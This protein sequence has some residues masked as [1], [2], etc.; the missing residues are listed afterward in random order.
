VAAG[1]FDAIGICAGSGGRYSRA[2]GAR[3]DDPRAP[4]SIDPGGVV[5]WHASERLGEHAG[6]AGNG[7]LG[8]A[9]NRWHGVAGGWWRFLTRA[10]SRAFSANLN[11]G[12]KKFTNILTL[13]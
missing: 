13:A 2:L 3:A 9:S 8:S 5:E 6:T 10:P 7:R 11:E 4:G 1:V 12:W